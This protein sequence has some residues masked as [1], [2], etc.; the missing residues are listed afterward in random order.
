MC[1]HLI[2]KPGPLA[3]N[4]REDCQ[5][6]PREGLWLGMAESLAGVS[7]FDC[8]ENGT[9]QFS[10]SEMTGFRFRSERCCGDLGRLR[11]ALGSGPAG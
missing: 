4:P 7:G 9:E 10:C 8:R 3:L 2:A 11:R 5:F 6:R 1:F